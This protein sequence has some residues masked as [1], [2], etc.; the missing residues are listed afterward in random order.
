MFKQMDADESVEQSFHS[1]KGNGGC[2]ASMQIQRHF[3]G[4]VPP[5][6]YH[7][8]VDRGPPGKRIKKYQILNCA[9]A[10][11]HNSSLIW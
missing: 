1:A 5:S 4:D 10:T 7:V 9:S 2:V 6:Q 3:F 8:V 11:K